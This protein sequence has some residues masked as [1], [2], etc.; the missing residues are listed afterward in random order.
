[1]SGSEGTLVDLPESRPVQRTKAALFDAFVELVLE[2]RYDQLKVADI[3][4]RAGVGRSTFYEHYEGKDEL[5]KAGLAG[6]FGVLADTVTNGHDPVR[7]LATVE[8]FWENRRVGN[9]LFAGQTRQLVAKTL[10]GLIEARLSEPAEARDLPIA[11]TLLAA[12]IA[13]G[14]MALLSAWLAGQAPAS[15]A[16]I[17]D[18][19]HG[20][21]R[22]GTSRPAVP[23]PTIPG[24]R[25]PGGAP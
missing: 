3:I 25:L 10:A 5:L 1:M 20:A 12:Q 21:A 17:A 11:P 7:L 6:P 14:Q 15:A 2:R 9:V 24:S 18:A 22:T 23:P 13:G 8:H 19:L 16:A 4:A